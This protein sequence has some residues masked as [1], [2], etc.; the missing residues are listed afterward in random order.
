MG[1]SAGEA[2][3]EGRGPGGLQQEAAKA[4]TRLESRF[5]LEGGKKLLSASTNSENQKCVVS[6]CLFHDFFP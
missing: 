5:T 1:K 4:H 6:I 3:R 2:R